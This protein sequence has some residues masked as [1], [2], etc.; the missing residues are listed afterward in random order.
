VRIRVEDSG[1]GIPPDDRERIF[2]RFYRV[3][4]GRDR[5]RGGAGLGLSICRAIVEAHGGTIAVGDSGL[6]GARFDVLLPIP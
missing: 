3:D 4:T 2:D 1:P 5:S 6:G